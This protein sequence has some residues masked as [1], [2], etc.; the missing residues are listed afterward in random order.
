MADLSTVLKEVIT[1]RLGEMSLTDI[2][3][4]TLGRSLT[5]N[6]KIMTQKSGT[7][8]KPIVIDDDVSPYPY[9]GEAITTASNDED[10]NPGIRYKRKADCGDTYY[11]EFEEIN[12]IFWLDPYPALFPV[13]PKR[14]KFSVKRLKAGK[15]VKRSTK[16]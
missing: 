7:R 2:M 10:D 8:A 16:K 9:T 3:V 13:K 11:Q 15:W 12:N 14:T 5:D 1:P 4:E 6:E